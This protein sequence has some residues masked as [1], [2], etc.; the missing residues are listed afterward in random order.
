MSVGRRNWSTLSSL[1]RQ[2]T[3]EDE[4]EVER[5]RRRR[6]KSSSN[7]TDSN[8]CAAAPVDTPASDQGAAHPPETSQDSS[9]TEQ[10]PLDFMEMLRVRDE[11]RRMRHMESRTCQ[12][13]VNEDDVESRRE[14]GREGDREELTAEQE[15]STK[16]QPQQQENEESS[17]KDALCRQPSNPTRKFVSSV[18]ISLDKSPSASGQTTPVSPLS[19]MTPRSPREHC[20]SPCSSL[21]PK[22]PRSPIPNGHTPETSAMSSSSNNNSEQTTKPLLIRKSSRTVSFRMIRKNEETSPLQRSASVRVASKKFESQTVKN[23]TLNEYEAPA[24]QRNSVQRVSS[25]SIQEKMARLAQAAQKSETGR[26]PDVSQ[27]TLYLLDEVSRKR[28]IFEKEPQGDSPL[29]PSKHELRGSTSGMSDRI[30]R[31]L[32]KSNPTGSTS[33]PT[34]VRNVDFTSKR[35]LFERRGHENV[36]NYKQGQ[37]YK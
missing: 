16:N 11:R 27:R 8:F 37:I 15:K 28:C 18:S 29:S 19:P 31:W 4:E 26:C 36:T 6:V 24:F 21:S 22:G 23:E 14:G 7:D 9:S 13:G 33:S 32:D 20:F 3:M 12:K 25:R 17:E 34:E 1:A 30:N 35:S 2:W 5:E 10:I